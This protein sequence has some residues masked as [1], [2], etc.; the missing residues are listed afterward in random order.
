MDE[1]W[2]NP[3]AAAESISCYVWLQDNW[4]EAVLS[5]LHL[6]FDRIKD[7]RTEAWSFVTAGRKQPND[8]FLKS[9]QIIMRRGL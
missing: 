3:D 4:S 5:S 2:E 9:T 1:H 6:I 7:G 8:V